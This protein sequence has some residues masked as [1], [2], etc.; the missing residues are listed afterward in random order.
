[1]ND[2]RLTAPGL[3]DERFGQSPN[4]TTR[5]KLRDALE[6]RIGAVGTVQPWDRGPASRRD[7]TLPP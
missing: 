7:T 3:M 4:N 5:T 2:V 1:L 6:S